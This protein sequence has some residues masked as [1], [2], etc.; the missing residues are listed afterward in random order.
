MLKGSGYTVIY[1][2]ADIEKDQNYLSVNANTFG[3]EVCP[4][5]SIQT[6][7]LMHSVLMYLCHTYSFPPTTY[8]CSLS[9]A[10]AKV[11]S[12]RITIFLQKVHVDFKATRL[13]RNIFVGKNLKIYV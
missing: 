12:G 5:G 10:K 11:H 13:R 2:M 7:T 1:S 6:C 3:K 4:N 9:V 8:H